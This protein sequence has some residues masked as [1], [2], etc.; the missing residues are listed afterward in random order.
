MSVPNLDY[1]MIAVGV[2]TVALV[3]G[4]IAY[5]FRRQRQQLKDST[6]YIDA[7][8]DTPSY[9]QIEWTAQAK[10]L[11]TTGKLTL[12]TGFVI[13][14]ASGFFIYRTLQ[15]GS[16]QE[17][18]YSRW[19]QTAGI[20]LVAVVA[21]IITVN[22][23]R[24]REGSLEIEYENPGG[25]NREEV[26]PIDTTEID[27]DTEGNKIVREYRKGRVV[28]LFRKQKLVGEDPDLREKEKPPNK[29][30]THQIPEHATQIGRNT[31][32]IRTKR[33]KATTETGGA[34]YVY[35][36]PLE[37]KYEEQIRRKEELRRKSA[38]IRVLE[39]TVADIE[40]EL[41]KLTDQM[42]SDERSIRKEVL[43]DL[44]ELQDIVDQRP[45]DADRPRQTHVSF[46]GKANGNG[47]PAEGV[48][49]AQQA[50]QADV[51]GGDSP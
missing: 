28:G 23:I 45:T 8:G 14:L 10:A 12:G 22:T 49:P 18:L 9:E 33:Q 48:T 17:I 3:I 24:K 11:S 5:L 40:R 43:E 51:S 47:Q 26:I 35:H 21:T 20:I 30:V 34:D 46:N 50:A 13:L 15:T 29:P 44:R 2:L 31:W 41:A 32:H 1:Q 39:A 6:D 4:V 19:V 42:E 27:A 37:T 36:A 7:G 38:R 25:E 16:P